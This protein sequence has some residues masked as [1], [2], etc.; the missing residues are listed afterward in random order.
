MCVDIWNGCYE[1]D[2]QAYCEGNHLKQQT[3]DCLKPDV[4]LERL[5]R[6]ENGDY[7]PFDWQREKR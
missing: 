2:N 7:Y 5:K 1:Y 6:I 4:Y 3:K